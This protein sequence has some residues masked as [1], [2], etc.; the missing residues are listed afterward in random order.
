MRRMIDIQGDI[1]LAPLAHVIW[2]LTVNPLNI[3]LDKLTWPLVVPFRH[4][5][6]TNIEIFIINSNII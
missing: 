2:I 1:K 6:L 3:I 4:C 5:G